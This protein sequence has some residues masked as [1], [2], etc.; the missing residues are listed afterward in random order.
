MKRNKRNKLPA[1]EAYSVSEIAQIF[2]I[3]I[4]TV[5]RRIKD[6]VIPVIPGLGRITRVPRSWVDQQIGPNQPE[7]SPN[8]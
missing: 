8:C 6:K 4:S 5:R 3:G 7:P 2:G 1:L